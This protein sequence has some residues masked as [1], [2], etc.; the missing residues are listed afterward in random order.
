MYEGG[1]ETLLPV[2]YF[3]WSPA[4]WWEGR[5]CCS[6][7]PTPYTWYRP[8]TPQ[9]GTSSTKNS[10]E[11]RNVGSFLQVMRKVSTSSTHPS[12]SVD[13]LTWRARTEERRKKVERQHCAMSGSHAMHVYW[14]SLLLLIGAINASEHFSTLSKNACLKIRWHNLRQRPSA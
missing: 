14:K 6:S 7:S 10:H 8:L 3:S 5:R 11:L 2:H 9:Q 13:R 4:R 1:V 12:Q